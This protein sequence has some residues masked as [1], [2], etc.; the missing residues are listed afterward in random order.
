[1]NGLD[2]GDLLQRVGKLKE[3]LDRLRE[4]DKDFVSEVVNLLETGKVVRR[5][6]ILRIMALHVPGEP[7]LE[8]SQDAGI[9]THDIW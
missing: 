7:T 1:V 6:Q 9:W 4:I 5:R 8:E 2:G 3:N